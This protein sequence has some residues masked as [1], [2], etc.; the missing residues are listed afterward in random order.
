M[1]KHG[2]FARGL[3]I[4]AIVVVGAGVVPGVVFAQVAGR[5]AK[6]L[7]AQARAYS[8]RGGYT[9]APRQQTQ[10][11]V[12][13]LRAAERRTHR[14]GPR[15]RVEVGATRLAP[16]AV[17]PQVRARVSPQ[18]LPADFLLYQNVDLGA[19]IGLT[20][21]VNEPSTAS[22]QDTVFY[23]YNWGAAISTNGGTSFSHVDP[24]TFFP[25][26]HDG[27]C[28]D[29]S[30]IYDAA[31]DMML[32]MLMYSPDAT[33]NN[34]RVA[35][36]NSRT[37]LRSGVWHFYDLTPS[38]ITYAGQAVGDWYDYPHMALNGTNLF[39]SINIFSSADAW[40]AT[41]MLRLP[42][43]ALDSGAALNYD[44]L[45]V[46][47]RF[48]FTAT[49]GAGATMYWGSHNS[50]SSLR[51]YRWTDGSGTID[52]DD[53]THT[54]YPSPFVTYSCPGP[55][56]V[57]WCG[58]SDDR[59]MTGW[60]AG[61]VIGFLW[62][63][64]QGMGGF[65]SFGWP[66]IHAARFN[67]ATRALIDEPIVSSSTNVWI[68]PSIGVNRRGHIAGPAYWGNGSNHPTCN[69]LIWDDLTGGG[70]NN[71][72]VR[73]GSHTPVTPNRWGDY[74][75]SRTNATPF[76][77]PGNQWVA[78]CHTMQGG[79]TD[80]NAR[81]QY[82]RF[83]RR[84]DQ[85]DTVGVFNPTTSFY[86]LRDSNVA[87]PADVTFGYGPGSAGWTAL[88]GDWDANE[89]DTPGLYNPVTSTF[90]LR[91]ANSAGAANVVFGYGPAGAGWIP[92]IGDWNGDGTD[93]VG[94]YDPTTS[95]FFLRN[96]NSAGAANVVFGYGPAGAGWIPIA[97]DWNGDGTDTIG[98]Y[99]PATSTF[100]LRNTNS[101]GPADVTFSY[102][103]AAG[104][105]PLAGNWN[106]TGMATIGLYNPATATFFLRFTN[107]AG[108]AD[109]TF[110]YGP[111]GL[112]WMPL[113][114]DW[115]SH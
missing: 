51:I 28:C 33:G 27:F 82:V 47:D 71:S 90:F 19:G 49:H 112:G 80:S 73:S 54:S 77:A 5:S 40:R 113:A 11:D 98:L 67:E 83:G 53:V 60:V 84:R 108:P 50:T 13:R 81:P 39:I 109:V 94:L 26:A 75:S 69:V 64:P 30:V 38:Q 88:S 4:L 86:F 36:A 32:W 44:Y 76:R 29:Q 68:Y 72:F 2:Q 85:L 9:Q 34:V 115:D 22:N 104:W 52:W 31:R 12:E 70:W 17:V 37:N 100:F 97:G 95:T 74:T 16:R 103:P 1:G 92:I 93:T 15:T 78:S 79:G 24:F 14:L 89:I 42:L 48:N 43:T 41:V 87:G 45:A 55:N 62:N 6:A 58:R 25:S 21:Q 107:T 99:N 102:G 66:Y 61:G 3:S 96:A 35:V 101:A 105:T 20:S 46:T 18:G 8:V 114:R 56:G 106:A 23:S 65:G 57:N 10:V 59:V 7:R 110:S 63:A 111:A 91:N